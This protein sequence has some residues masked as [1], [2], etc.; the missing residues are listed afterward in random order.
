MLTMRLHSV[1]FIGLA[2]ASGFGL[3]ACSG[4]IVDI[5][6]YAPSNDGGSVDR[7]S[8]GAPDGGGSG[9]V[10][11]ASDVLVHLIASTAP[12]QHTDD[13][14]GQTPQDQRIGI[15]GLTLFKSSSD[16]TPFVVF[17]H[18]ANAVEAGLNDGD[19]TLVGTTTISSLVPGTYVLAR[20]AVS[21]VR[22]V[23]GATMHGPVTVPGAF[24]NFQVLSTNSTI[25]GQT[26]DKGH[27]TYVFT[28]GGQTLGTQTGENAP[29]PQVPSTGGVTL[30]SAGSESAYVF[31]VNLTIPSDLAAPVRIDFTVNT[32]EDFRW[33]DQQMPGYA[34]GVFDVTPTTFEPVLRFGANSFSLALR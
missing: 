34:E 32:H 12:V 24:Q 7:S 29:V 3:A 19:D 26:Y 16:A 11:P 33:Q 15:R 9:D 1:P 30:E 6:S 4:S 5:G 8:V 27:Y 25:D 31:P 2:L 18:G 14:A 13:L 23:V 20:V 10:D 22:Y 28:A 21:H 17:D